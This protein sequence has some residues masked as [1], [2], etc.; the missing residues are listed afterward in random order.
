MLLQ[1]HFTDDDED[2][3]DDTDDFYTIF[4]VDLS[5]SFFFISLLYRLLL[6]AV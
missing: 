3:D 1:L 5:L 2:E 4:S 6:S